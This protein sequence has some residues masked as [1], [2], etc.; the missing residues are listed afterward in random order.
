MPLA[1][2]NHKTPL[3]FVL[4]SY[5]PAHSA[6]LLAN[7]SALVLDYIARQKVG[8]ASMSY[9]LLKQL[10]FIP[11]DRYT[12]EDLE[13]IS[14]RVLQLT[15]T[16]HDVTAWG[17]DLG[18]GGQPFDFDIENRA[19][20]RAE[21]DAYFARLYGLDRNEL[22]YILDPADVMGPD[23]PTETFRVLKQ[24][25]MNTKGVNEYRTRRLVLEAW[26]QLQA[27]TLH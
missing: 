22:R 24:R 12:A 4:P 13:F 21:L 17:S 10:P 5:S 7:F 2:V 1:A 27:G 19:Q 20:I 23:Y 25:E 16:A 6:A 15:Y 14:Q 8:G 18:Y 11:P 3:W 26:D 9:F